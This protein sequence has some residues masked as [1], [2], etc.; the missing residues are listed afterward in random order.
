MIYKFFIL[1]I[2]VP[3]VFKL[4]KFDL[5]IFDDFIIVLIF[6]YLSRTSRKNG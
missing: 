6:Y 1:D 3:A 4:F 2:L 5:N